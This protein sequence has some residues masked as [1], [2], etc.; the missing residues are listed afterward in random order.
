MKRGDLA[1]PRML[2]LRALGLGDFCTAVPAL[3]ALRRAFPEHELVLA[4]PAWQA[5]LA[6]MVSVDRLVATQ[7]LAPLPPRESAPSLAVNL[8]GRGPQSTQL[9]IDL[10][11]S[12]LIA[13]RHPVLPPTDCSPRWSDDEHEVA[14]WCR[15]LTLHGIPAKS[16]DLRLVPPEAP[17]P[18]P[19]HVIVHPGAA[20][21]GRRWP[22]ERFAAVISH[23][24]ATGE[25]VAVT[26]TRAER[27]LSERIIARVN[28]ATLGAVV[29]LC[30]RTTVEQLCATVAG[31]RAVL[32]NDT[33]VAH[34]AYAFAV[35]SVVLFGPTPPSR[36]GPPPGPHIALWKG[37][38]GDPHGEAVHPG[39]LA[40]HPAEVVEAIESLV[41]TGSDGHV[42][43]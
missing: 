5:P 1:R 7:P 22:P 28:G 38:H 20:A 23:L 25:R 15:L 32:S 10:A 17:S 2:V 13:F 6:G 39:L 26:G 21:T 9:L 12:R 37:L 29:N 27:Q 24:L 42:S 34:L 41:P 4:A 3:K 40:I 43:A 8:H 19:D 11:P 31:A 14:R 35:P 18:A 33:G 30:G 36:W 16:T